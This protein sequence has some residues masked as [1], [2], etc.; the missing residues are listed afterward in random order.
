MTAPAQD[1]SNSSRPVLRCAARANRHG[2]GGGSEAAPPPLE[3]AGVACLTGPRPIFWSSGISLTALCDRLEL[4]LRL[5][6]PCQVWIA[7]PRA[8]GDH[9]R[10]IKRCERHSGRLVLAGDHFSLHLNEGRIVATWVMKP[11]R[12]DR[13]GKILELWDCSGFRCAS[14]LG[15]LGDPERAA[16]HDVMDSLL[17]PTID[18]IPAPRRLRP[19]STGRS[20]SFLSDDHGARSYRES[21]VEPR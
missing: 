7:V 19:V 8:P 4:L 6:V 5:E 10:T 15:P 12:A 17:V 1:A 14:I 21:V 9:Y 13:F 3:P 11:W 16:W 20:R 18:P 2:G